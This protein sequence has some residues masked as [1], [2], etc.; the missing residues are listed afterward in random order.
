PPTTDLA[1]ATSLGGLLFRQRTG[2]GTVD[3]RDVVVGNTFADVVTNTAGNPGPV[4]IA[5]NVFNLTNYSGNP[6]L[7]EVFATSLG[8]GPLSY[9]WYQISSGVTNPVPGANAQ[10]YLIP[11]LS[12]SDQGAY[13]CAVSNGVSGAWSKTNFV[14]VNTAATPP[15]FTVQPKN[16]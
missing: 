16:T 11:S 6:A 8:G 3:I 5:T 9:Q 10:V 4:M 1:G 7:M 2:G 14:S 15:T 12:G 13:F